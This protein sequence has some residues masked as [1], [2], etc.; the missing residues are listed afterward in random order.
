MSAR[1]AR[2]TFT[3]AGIY[4]LIVLMPFFFLERRIAEATPGGLPHAEY[5]YG[6]LGA[7]SVMQ[8]VYLTI[9]RDPVRFRPLMPL[10]ALAKVAFFLP[11]LILWAEQ[12][13]PA[14][15]LEFAS[16]DAL[17]AA[18]FIHAWRVTPVVFPNRSP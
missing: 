8:L 13:I 17:L 18:A 15:V 5:Y 10:C 14:A 12:R 9:A 4:G 6:F 2:L 3:L 1:T 11:V 7:A 16:I